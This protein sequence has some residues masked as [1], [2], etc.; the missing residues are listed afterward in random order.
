MHCFGSAVADPPAS[1]GV[2][3]QNGAAEMAL[4]FVN[5]PHTLPQ[6][7]LHGR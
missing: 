2:V 1:G 6:D 3:G 4:C 7:G 5:D